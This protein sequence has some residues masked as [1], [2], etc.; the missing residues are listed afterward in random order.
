MAEIVKIVGTRDYSFM[1][2]DSGEL[3]T[4]RRYYCVLSSGSSRTTGLETLDLPASTALMS[5]WVMPGCFTPKVGD[6]AE[7]VYSRYGR[8]ESFRLV[9]PASAAPLFESL[10]A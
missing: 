1:A 2:R 8:L 7:V 6:F 3:V 10:L 4:G 5:T 9:D